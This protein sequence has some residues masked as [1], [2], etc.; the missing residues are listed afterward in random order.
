MQYEVFG[1]LRALR[2]RAPIDLGGPMARKLLAA[3]LLDAPRTVDRDTLVERLWGAHPPATATTALQVHVSH[4]RRALDPDYPRGARSVLRTTDEGYA[5]DT[6]RARVDADRFESL[7]QETDDLAVFDPERALRVVESARELWRGRPWGAL[8]DEPWLRGDVARLEELR[9]RAD[10][11]SAE[12]HLALGHHELI[13]DALARAVEAEP[14]RER[15]WEQLMTALYRCGRQADAL[16]AFQDARHTLTEELG[17]EPSSALRALDQAVLDQDPSLDAPP[18][19]VPQ[20]PRHN[21]PAALT[22]LVGRVDDVPATR[23]L[24]EASRLVTITGT[25]GCG[26]TRLALAVAEQLVDRY[27]DGVWFVDLG[28]VSNVDGA[29][30]QIASDLGL[31]DGDQHA[32]QGP[33][34]LLHEYLRG[35]ELLLVLDNCEHVVADVATVVGSLLASCP[36]LRV[37]ATSR[38]VIGV[39]GENVNALSPLDVPHVDASIDDI[40]SS[41]AVQL[42]LQRAGDAGA[43]H[44]QTT[45]QLTAIGK[46]C[47]FLDGVPLA[48]ELAAMWTATLT[49]FEILERLASRLSLAATATDDALSDRQRALR[50]TIEWSHALLADTERVAFRRL[51]VFPAG[52]TLAGAGAVIAGDSDAPDAV[53]GTIA[54]LVGSSLVR[55]DH[56]V[57]ARYRMLE[58]IREYAAEQLRGNREE[59]Q[60]RDRQL[61]YFVALARNAKPDEF[62]G[63][64]VPETMSALDGEHDNIREALERLLAARDGERA[65]LL[66][67]V[68]GTYWFERGHW[69]E[70]QRWLTRALELTAGSPTLPR[71]RALTALA[72][73]SSSFAGIAARVGELEESVE[74]YRNH[75]AAQ[76]DAQLEIVAALMYVS[77]A[78]A[79][80]RETAPM[81]AASHEAKKIAASQGSRWVDATIAVYESLA[82]VIEGDLPGA[83]DGLVQD[84]ADLLDLG[85]EPFAARAL[86]YAGNVSRLLDDLPAARQELELS[87]ELARAHRIHGTHAHGTL[88]LAQVAMQQGEAD[89]SS[90]FL[91]CLA[92]LELIGDARC[93]AVCQRSLGSL[94]LDAG[95]PDEALDWLQQSLEPLA[96]YDRRTLAVAIADLATI[97]A[98][99]GDTPDAIRLAA[100]AQA[101]AREPGMPLAA[102]ERARIDAAIAATKA[103]LGTSDAGSSLD[104]CAVDVDVILEVARQR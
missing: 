3:L 27:D 51:S 45:E 26:K 6:D 66:A 42:F 23:K 85:D 58:S 88:A 54:R 49:P 63:P 96:A 90:L 57:P 2:A 21:L 55:P 15:R 95:R 103:D 50:T 104:N 87:K 69:G 4:L 52:F 97:R 61:N 11:L 1:E 37:L 12:V 68:M 102:S 80:R 35:R 38:V 70:G 47:R 40:G 25:G 22:S 30:T 59:D 74:I 60:T 46:L 19:S 67:G 101:L 43:S 28:A 83:R 8:A 91:D 53:V 77:L 81:R 89:A 48:I 24:L 44:D 78:R 10:E 86:M 99:R 39:V 73:T 32:P 41:P 94:A 18:R 62:F 20:R 56:R 79:W 31:R 64:P 92:A 100:A 93:T 33:M 72:Q 29:A 13:V 5:L 84:A 82:L 34:A 36:R 65:V 98:Q 7:V 17:I 9:R 75:D 71:A 16:R 76:H 14:L